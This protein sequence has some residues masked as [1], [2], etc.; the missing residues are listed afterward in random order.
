MLRALPT[1]GED[2]RRPP[3]HQGTDVATKLRS[4]DELNGGGT[5]FTVTCL[6][7]EGSPRTF[8]AF[9]VPGSDG[10]T[11]YLSTA[12]NND[13]LREAWEVTAQFSS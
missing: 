8:D 3:H 13:N 7:G 6:D 11:Y 4:G 5:P 12:C 10:G 2:V 9:P 1:R